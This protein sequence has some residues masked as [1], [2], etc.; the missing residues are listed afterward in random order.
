MMVSAHATNTRRRQ[1]PPADRID[2]TR[3]ALAKFTAAIP[4]LTDTAVR[5]SLPWNVLYLDQ[6][7]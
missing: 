2:E 5:G 7:E 6:R 4:D 3:H 1:C